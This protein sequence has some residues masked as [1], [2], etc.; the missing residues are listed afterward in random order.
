MEDESPLY[1]VFII[2]L[3][4]VITY[5]RPTLGIPHLPL[6]CG[7]D[8]KIGSWKCMP[9]RTGVAYVLCTLKVS[10]RFVTHNIF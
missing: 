2:T 9:N 1:L 3:R 10:L 4:I 6:Q 7:I 5:A 8:N